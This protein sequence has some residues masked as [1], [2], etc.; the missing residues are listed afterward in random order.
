MNLKKYLQQQ[1]EKDAESLITE[2]DRQFSM[3][4]AQSAPQTAPKHKR[5]NFA[6]IS[7]VAAVCLIAVVLGITLPLTL[8]K[9]PAVDVI[10]YKEENVVQ[11]VCTIED[12][13]Y[14]SKY[15]KIEADEDLT[16]RFQLN[17]D[18]VS[19]DKLYY[20]VIVSTEISVFT[21]NIVINENY[22]FSFEMSEE[23]FHEPLSQYAVEYSKKSVD[24][25]LTTQNIYRGYV[26]VASETVYVDYTQEFDLGAQADRAFFDEIQSILKVKN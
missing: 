16:F 4:L 15:F 26:K 3:Q 6:A 17:Y 7:S 12:V 2:G 10:R 9:Q 24:G 20:S 1:A 21:L 22:K 19:G 5:F 18:S 8:N 25:A 13:N 23:I 11:T 14:N